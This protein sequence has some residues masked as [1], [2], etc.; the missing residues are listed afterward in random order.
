MKNH[1]CPADCGETESAERTD[2][3]GMLQEIAL[4]L[5]NGKPV[6]EK[7]KN[8]EKMLKLVDSVGKQ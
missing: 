7:M 4:C 5:K 1:D 2:R 3:Y 6:E 8:Y